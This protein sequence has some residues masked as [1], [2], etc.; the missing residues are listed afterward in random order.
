MCCRECAGHLQSDHGPPPHSLQ[1]GLRVHPPAL[2]E[3]SQETPQLPGV[4]TIPAGMENKPTLPSFFFFLFTLLFVSH[5]FF[6]RSSG[7][8]CL[9]GAAVGARPPSVRPEGQ[10]EERRYL[11][12]GLQ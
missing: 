9:L 2:W 6:S 7:W 11:C 1:L 12:Y 10:R 3:R 4:H 8:C 5:I